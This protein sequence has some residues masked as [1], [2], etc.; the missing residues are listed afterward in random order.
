M[1]L[2][3]ARL[4]FGLTVALVALAFVEAAAPVCIGIAGQ[5]LCRPGVVAQLRAMRA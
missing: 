5:G 1:M 2:L 3:A 4:A